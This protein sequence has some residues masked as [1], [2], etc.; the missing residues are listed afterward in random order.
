MRNRDQLLEDI[1]QDFDVVIIGGGI[2]GAVSAAALSAHGVK[3]AL[4]EAN[5]FASM[6]SQE[7]SNMIWGG[8]KYLQD[9][10]FSLVWKLCKSR[11]QLLK[12]YPN[13]IKQIPFLAVIGPT[14]PFNRK[15]GFLGTVAYWI[16]GRFQT[17]LP[18]VFSNTRLIKKNALLNLSDANGAVQYNDAILLD[19]DSRFVF[20]FIKTA[21]RF[22][23]VPLNYFKVDK[24]EKTDIG[25]KVTGTNQLTGEIKEIKSKVLINATGPLA[26]QL[27][28]EMGISTNNEIVISKGVHLIVPKMETN[29][30][31]LA[32]FDTQGR[33][34]YVLPMHDCTVIGTTDTAALN[35]QVSVTDED[36]DFLLSQANKNLNLKKPLTK[37][38]I[39]SERCGVRPLVVAGNK[40]ITKVDWI[41][42][43]RK[44]LVEV[45]VDSKSISIFGGKL[46]DCINIGNEIVH[47]IKKL[48]VK[49]ASAENW[50]GEPNP[51]IPA[52]L[53]QIV[54]KFHGDLAFLVAESLWRRHGIDSYSIIESW[55]DDAELAEIA[56]EGLL[57]TIGELEYIAENELVVTQDDLLRRRTPIAL[58]RK[59]PLDPVS[60]ELA[61]ANVNWNSKS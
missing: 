1:N 39:I 42:L 4:F 23:A 16:F 18:R 50:I 40:K 7:S 46:T 38:D 3:V 12:K 17:H 2:N 19:N 28:D 54:A 51:V 53:V 11:N 41:S 57:F 9:Y 34:F 6:T 33:L 15:L 22:G 27:N 60:K 29:Q 58:L 20:E 44:H 25:W 26:R 5:D 10:E 43:S 30:K 14:S 55:E 61:Q 13:R 35:A 47:G 24:A 36:R 56:Y 21:E 45:K 31:V 8:I 52:D 48:G 59:Q 32:F 37:Q 49:T